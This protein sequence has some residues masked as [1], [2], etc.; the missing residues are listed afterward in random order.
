MTITGQDTDVRQAH[1]ALDD[2]RSSVRLRAAPAGGTT[3][4]PRF[5]GKLVE[6][7]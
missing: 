1:L 2:G 4:D 3:P 5:V 6:R 7:P